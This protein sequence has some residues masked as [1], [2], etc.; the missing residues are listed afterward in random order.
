MRFYRNQDIEKITEQ[1]LLEFNDFSR[2]HLLPQISIESFVE[3]ILGL[4]L[5]WDDIEEL[6]GETILGA[7]KATDQLIV[8]NENRRALFEEKPG[9]LRTTIGHEAG[10]WDLFI[11]KATFSIHACSHQMTRALS[12][13]AAPE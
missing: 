3:N 12:F 1:K 10:H 5:L 7:L 2:K 8:L 6:P 11:D 4:N 13:F 9:L